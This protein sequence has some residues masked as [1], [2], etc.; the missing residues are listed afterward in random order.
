MLSNQLTW[1]HAGSLPTHFPQQKKQTIIKENS[2]SPLLTHSS[3]PI[4]NIINSFSL[5]SENKKKNPRCS[6]GSL[7]SILTT[8]QVSRGAELKL[9]PQQP[10]L[11]LS[12]KGLCT[13]CAF[14]SSQ[15]HEP[16]AEPATALPQDEFFLRHP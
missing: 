14:L 7:T 16:P 15:T 11:V 6:L 10:R 4:S 12:F 13:D 9:C 2:I 5:L 1:I 8:S 3:T